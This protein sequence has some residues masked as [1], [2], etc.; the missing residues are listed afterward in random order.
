VTWQDGVLSLRDSLSGPCPRQPS[1]EL[2]RLIGRFLALL[3]QHLAETQQLR[4]EPCPLQGPNDCAIESL[5][6]LIEI[7]TG[8]RGSM[9]RSLIAQVA[10]SSEPFGA[11]H[12]WRRAWNCTADPRPRSVTKQPQSEPTSTNGRKDLPVSKSEQAEPVKR[13][14]ETPRPPLHVPRRLVINPI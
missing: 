14:V 13:D 9:S 5:N 10:K 7:V 4:L 11:S 1:I 12:I 2:K 6:N 8:R 3:P